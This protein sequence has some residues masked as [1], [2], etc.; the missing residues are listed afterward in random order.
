MPASHL[1]GTEDIFDARVAR[2]DPAI[3][4]LGDKYV[5]QRDVARVLQRAGPGQILSPDSLPGQIGSWTPS[6]STTE[7]HVHASCRT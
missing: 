6:L 4:G 3:V 2:N 1:Q 5:G 7:L